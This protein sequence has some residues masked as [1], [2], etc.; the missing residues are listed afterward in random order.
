[1][2]SNKGLG[3]FLGNTIKKDTLKSIVIHLSC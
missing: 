1:L 2:L 3:N